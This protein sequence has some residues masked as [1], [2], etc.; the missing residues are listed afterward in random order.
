M[1]GVK[2]TDLQSYS[3]QNDAIYR[4]AVPLKEK[5][6]IL[7]KPFKNMYQQQICPMIM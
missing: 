1:S 7:S 3:V 5:S 4:E 2:N 6:F